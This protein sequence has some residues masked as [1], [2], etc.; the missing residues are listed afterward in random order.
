MRTSNVITQAEADAFAKF[1][2][3]N[4][5]ETEGAT[6]EANGTALGGPIVEQG[7]DVTAQTLASVFAQIKDRGVL[8]FKSP[9]KANY[10][11]ALALYCP[12]F[13]DQ[14]IFTQ[15]FKA[16]SRHMVVEGDFGYENATKVLSRLQGKVIDSARL[17]LELSRCFASTTMHIT[18]KIERA[19]SPHSGGS[20]TWGAPESTI[21]FTGGRSYRNDPPTAGTIESSGKNADNYWREKCQGIGGTHSQ[22]ASLAK[23]FVQKSD[24]SGVDWQATHQKRLQIAWNS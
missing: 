24:G 12:T 17:D 23:L 8:V 20:R 7:F 14:E 4:H 3:E 2:L 5:I 15:W 21:A 9:A 13:Q 22:Q 19:Y 16:Q 18:P 1:A 11:A 10:D 6:G